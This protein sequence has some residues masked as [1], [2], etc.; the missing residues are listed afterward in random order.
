MVNSI[1]L[2]SRDFTADCLNGYDM[3]RRDQ[4]TSGLLT[5]ALIYAS[6]VRRKTRSYCKFLNLVL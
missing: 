5:Y 3:A 4:L 1:R 6:V 2:T